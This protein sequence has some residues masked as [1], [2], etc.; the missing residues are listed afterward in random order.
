MSKK[1]FVPCFKKIK[2]ITP[3]NSLKQTIL[4]FFIDLTNFQNPHKFL[5]RTPQKNTFSSAQKFPKFPIK[6]LIKSYQLFY[7]FTNPCQN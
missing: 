6:N 1:S 2:I 3:L 5:R 7:K 4:P